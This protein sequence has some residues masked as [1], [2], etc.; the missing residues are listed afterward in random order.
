MPPEYGS[1]AYWDERFEKEENF[2][3]L[4]DGQAMIPVL[5]AWL[6]GDSTSPR[7]DSQASDGARVL[8]IGA[9]T[10]RLSNMV[11]RA[12][13]DVV[14][15]K[16][17]VVVN[18]DFSEAVVERGRQ[19]QEQEQGSRA[20]R[21]ERVDLLREEDVRGLLRAESSG[22]G[23]VAR[24]DAVIDKSTSDAIS[25]APDVWMKGRENAHVLDTPSTHEESSGTPVEALEVL[26]LHL[27][28]VVKPHG[29][30]IALSY[31][32][33]RFPFLKN[34][35]LCHD[36]EERDV[37]ACGLAPFAFWTVERK[38]AVDAPSGQSREGVHAPPVQHWIY[39]LRRSNVAFDEF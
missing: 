20:V 39:V 11:V 14:D 2:E 10:S 5:R 3:W 7:G 27:A 31:S 26:A 1:K 19:E 29:V 35:S 33:N 18:T 34:D 9:G 24:F 4:G 23:Q 25:C 36:A 15:A 17:L 37:H 13:S 38:E 32:S 30:W 12:L 16:G 28:A 8:H 21:W 22:T 6:L